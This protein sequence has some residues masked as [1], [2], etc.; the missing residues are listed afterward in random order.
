MDADLSAGLK[1]KWGLT[2]F[3]S[4]VLF[5]STQDL[6]IYLVG[7][8]NY[9]LFTEEKIVSFYADTLKAQKKF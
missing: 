5:S 4:F 1:V 8:N 2:Y 6:H 3:I 9:R 7:S